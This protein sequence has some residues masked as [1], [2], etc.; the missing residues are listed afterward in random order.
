MLLCICWWQCLVKLSMVQVQEMTPRMHFWNHR[1]KLWQSREVQH[2]DFLRSQIL[3]WSASPSLPLESHC[4]YPINL[5]D[6]CP[7]NYPAH[8]YRL[9]AL[10][11]FFEKGIMLSQSS[12]LLVLNQI[13]QF[14]V[15]SVS[16][17]DWIILQIPT[18]RIPWNFCCNRHCCA[19]GYCCAIE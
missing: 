1:R 14:L 5:I 8:S 16:K 6:H 15:Y 13:L 12:L 9:T 7:S 4:L 2:M 3:G 17:L 11:I 19:T 18:S 10:S